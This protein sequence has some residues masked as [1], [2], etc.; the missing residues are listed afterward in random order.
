MVNFPYFFDKA[1]ICLRLI[2]RFLNLIYPPKCIFCRRLLA[3]S[4]KGICR[5]CSLSLPPDE[6]P[7]RK[8]KFFES[9]T[10]CYEYSGVVRGSL[11]RY[12]FNG[13]SHYSE[14]Y[15]KLLAVRLFEHGIEDFDLVTWVPVS[16]RRK[17]RRGY[18]QAEL[19]ARS[20]ARE[21]SLPVTA[22]L[23]K[24]VDNPPQSQ[25]ASASERQAN[26]RGVYRVID[27]SAVKDKQILIIDDIVTTG[28]TLSECGCTLKI[29]GA[30][31]VHCG[32][33]AAAA[34]TTLKQVKT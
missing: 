6:S 20:V 23:E 13:A 19:L 24:F 7:E 31:S 32:A 10:A 25:K 28:A 2:D 8:S 11:L 1:V 21:L 4:E 16:R 3:E 27:V 14:L 29:A 34:Q 9:C 15:G 5:S 12:K 26:V 22:T 17:R 33:F 18:D 30:A